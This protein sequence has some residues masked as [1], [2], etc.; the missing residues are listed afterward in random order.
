MPIDSEPLAWIPACARDRIKVSPVSL[1]RSCGPAAEAATFPVELRQLRYFCAVAEELS[2]ARAARRLFIA[3][4]ALSVQVRHLEEEL[5]VRLLHRTTRAI[6]LTHAGKTFLTEARQILARVDVA[7]QHAQDAARGILGTL[8][9]AFLSN[10]AT[11]DL[12]GRMRVFRE[13]FPRVNLA[14]MEAPTHRQIELLLRGDIDVGLL[15]F[16]RLPTPGQRRDGAR[17]G[18]EELA[19]GLGFSSELLASEELGRQRMVAA[20]P[21]N[22]ALAK[23]KRLRWVDFQG[24]PMIGTS[25]PRERYFE[26][27]FACCERAQVRPVVTQYA[28]DLAMRLWMVACGFGFSP[29]TASSQEISRP[30]LAYR[31]LPADA[32]EVLTFAARRKQD[33]APHLLQFIEV[34]KDAPPVLPSIDNDSLSMEA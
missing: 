26:P 13:S 23:R 28:Q 34:L 7:G 33:Q 16:S 3:Q 17:V 19:A 4:P 8:R 20:V 11:A 9:V 32:P 10:V 24:E 2:F 21:A 14:L 1:R 27:F 29:T 22:G 25:D 18:L 15:R 6:E 30:G 5:K 31:P 12:G